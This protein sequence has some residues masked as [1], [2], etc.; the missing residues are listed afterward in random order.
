MGNLFAML[1]HRLVFRLGVRGYPGNDLRR[2]RGACLNRG[3]TVSGVP[4]RMISNPDNLLIV[5]TK[6]VTVVTET[7]SANVG[8]ETSESIGV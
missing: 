2:L 6:S 5:E 8:S 1:T 3:D 7:M 4:Y